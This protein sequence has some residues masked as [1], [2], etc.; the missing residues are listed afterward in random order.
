MCKNQYS[1]LYFLSISK[2]SSQISVRFLLTITQRLQAVRDCSLPFHP[3]TL[4]WVWRMSSC[5]RTVGIQRSN[6]SAYFPEEKRLLCLSGS[7]W[8]S[9]HLHKLLLSPPSTQM[10]ANRLDPEGRN[11]ANFQGKSPSEVNSKP[12]WSFWGRLAR[13]IFHSTVLYFKILL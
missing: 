10:R 1:P 9:S 13:K 3:S 6:T 5:G 4:S 7:S 11:V 8:G 12:C 2:N